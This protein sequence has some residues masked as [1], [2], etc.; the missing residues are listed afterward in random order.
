MDQP[1][2]YVIAIYS[3]SFVL[4]KLKNHLIFHFSFL[5][6]SLFSPRPKCQEDCE[7]VINFNIHI[8]WSLDFSNKHRWKICRWI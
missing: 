8:L 6:V 1:F 5:S 2:L 3:L 7:I 4:N